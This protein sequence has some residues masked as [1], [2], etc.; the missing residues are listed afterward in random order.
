M[1]CNDRLIRDAEGNCIPP[2]QC[3]EEDEAVDITAFLEGD[4]GNVTTSTKPP[5]IRSW[6]PAPRRKPGQP[7]PTLYSPLLPLGCGSC[8]FRTLLH[9]SDSV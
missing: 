1:S 2:E 7:Y 9:C 3:P 5:F 4:T 6:R 8:P